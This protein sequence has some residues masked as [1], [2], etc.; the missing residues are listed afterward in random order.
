MF[1]YMETPKVSRSE[2]LDLGTFLQGW[3]LQHKGKRTHDELTAVVI[4]AGP[5]G[6][7]AAIEL[8]R[9]AYRVLLIDRRTS[10]SR[11]NPVS[12]RE[13]FRRRLEQLGALKNLVQAQRIFLTTMSF[14][15]E[16]SHIQ[17][18]PRD[19]TP[20]TDPTYI[21]PERLT[22]QLSTHSAR[23]CDIEHAL[24]QSAI[25]SGV[26]VVENAVTRLSD[27]VETKR[28]RVELLLEHE[29]YDLG[30]PDLVVYATGDKDQ[31][32]LHDLNAS[33]N[34]G[35]FIAPEDLKLCKDGTIHRTAGD[36]ETQ[37][38]LTFGI[39]QLNKDPMSAIKPPIMEIHMQKYQRSCSSREQ[40]IFCAHFNHFGEHG[41]AL[42][43]PRHIK[44]DQTPFI[45]DYALSRINETFSTTYHDVE[46]LNL[47]CRVI[48]GSLTEA[49]TVSSSVLDAFTF[50]SNTVVIGDAAGSSCPG[51]GLGSQSGAAI[52]S[53]LV[54]TLA[55]GLRQRAFE[56]RS[57]MSAHADVQNGQA[58][59][60]PA[61]FHTCTSRVE[62]QT[63]RD[64]LLTNFSF[65][66][67]QT[68]E[69]W[70]TA[71]RAFFL[72]KHEAAEFQE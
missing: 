30:F 45:A 72:S 59:K 12:I 18:R 22:D 13:E 61:N 7:A 44:V 26:T 23:I 43:L 11:G 47:C 54:S 34:V 31:A 69:V 3:P 65:A 63:T 53:Q 39:R 16:W 33:R 50:G 48:Y 36:L 56:K 46:E 8:S 40:P 4:G 67:A 27:S 62:E 38:F 15:S 10:N 28:K 37:N 24:L 25:E 42:Q 52:D 29:S 41:F 64:Q 71:C 6:A 68:L 51:P 14:S 60:E 35:S 21:V 32:L 49:F 17:Y 70:G 55:Q 66:K 57:R 20:Y 2:K 58:D 5:S 9:Q 19:T 1:E